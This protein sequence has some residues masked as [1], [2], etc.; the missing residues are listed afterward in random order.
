MC[1]LVYFSRL[2]ARRIAWWLIAYMSREKY[3]YRWVLAPVGAHGAKAWEVELFLDILPRPA[4][5]RD[6]VRKDSG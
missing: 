2:V 1:E 3:V 6:Y 4:C 5:A